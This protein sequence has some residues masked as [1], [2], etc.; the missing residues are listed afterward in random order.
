MTFARRDRP[1]APLA[2]DD[3]FDGSLQIVA[4]GAGSLMG[5]ILPGGLRRHRASGYTESRIR[6]IIDMSTKRVSLAEANGHL[7]ELIDAAG[8][9]DEIVIEA[10]GKTPVRLT[11]VKAER[12]P[13][14]FGQHQGMVSISP[15]FDAPL[16]DA[17][18]LSGNP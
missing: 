2:V 10:E 7:A 9:G 4:G 13:R 3:L 5:D 15:D 14:V 17:F 16:P 18:W 12:K 8:R 11:L 1:G 6:G